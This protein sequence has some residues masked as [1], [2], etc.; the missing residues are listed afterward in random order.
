MPDPADDPDDTSPPQPNDVLEELA[1]ESAAGDLAALDALLRVLDERG[2]A[3]AAVRRTIL[4]DSDVDDVVQDVMVAVAEGIGGFRGESRF[5]T[6][7]ATVAR[8]KAIAHLRRQRDEVELA[9]DIGDAQRVSS[10]LATRAA[11]RDLLERLPEIYREVVV[12]CDVDQMRYPDIAER[13]GLNENTVR[14]RATR[15]R[16]LAASLVAEAAS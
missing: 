7:M 13:L 12:L 2:L 14:T 9:D 3:R 15:G 8:H 10:V 4:R 11:V 16:A 6:W 1:R 5:S